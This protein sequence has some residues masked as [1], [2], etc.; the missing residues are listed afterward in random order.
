MVA[1]LYL[2]ALG[3]TCETKV[4]I[5]GFII[6]QPGSQ[7]A[8]RLKDSWQRPERPERHF[9]PLSWIEASKQKG[10]PIPQIFVDKTTAEPVKI[11]IHAAIANPQYREELSVK[12]AV[13]EKLSLL[14]IVLILSNRIMAEKPV[15][16]VMKP[17]SY[18]LLQTPTSLGKC[19]VSFREMT[20]SMWST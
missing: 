4:P 15:H 8:Q 12:I 9:V 1:N 14:E 11:H 10:K 13:C 2:Q 6:Y 20:R 7:E 18:L 19:V 3:G 16:R 17:E 5:R